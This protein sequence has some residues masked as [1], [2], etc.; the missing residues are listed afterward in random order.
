MFGDSVKDE[1]ITLE[2]LQGV[3]MDR[4]PRAIHPLASV[5]EGRDVI[6]P[7]RGRKEDYGDDNDGYGQKPQSSRDP[8][9]GCS[10]HTHNVHRRPVDAGR[11]P[12]Q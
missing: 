8:P 11:R 7:C 6:Y 9:G 3:L 4:V 1:L 2:R 5:A 10:R 12:E